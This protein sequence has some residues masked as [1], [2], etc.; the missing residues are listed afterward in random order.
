S[1]SIKSQN[2]LGCL[3]QLPLASYAYNNFDI[4]LK[5]SN[6][7]EI[8]DPLKH[9][10]SRLLFLVVHGVCTDDLK[11]SDGLWWQSSLNPKIGGHLLPPKHT[12]QELV[13]IH[14][15]CLNDSNLS[16]HN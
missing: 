4:N 14:A 3:R 5:C 15:E 7:R 8:N 6:G 13:N 2:C 1:L 9:L 11:C 16:C 10:M 12:W